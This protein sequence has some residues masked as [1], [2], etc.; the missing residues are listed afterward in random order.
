MGSI[1]TV[2]TR[3]G[4]GNNELEVSFVGRLRAAALQIP[5]HWRA[6]EEE[7]SSL[8]LE[9][10]L[11]ALSLTRRSPL[12]DLCLPRKHEPRAIQWGSYSSH[13]HR[14]T[15]VAP[16]RLELVLFDEGTR[17]QLTTAYNQE[18]GGPK[19]AA[20]LHSHLQ[21]A[22]S[23]TATCDQLFARQLAQTRIGYCLYTTRVFF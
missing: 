10:I 5:V 11:E 12:C 4:R 8:V 9:E 18:L 14:A 6:R 17:R 2:T 22:A 15:N 7:R 3:E 20:R 16:A 19:A 1:A 23:S 13:R 21:V